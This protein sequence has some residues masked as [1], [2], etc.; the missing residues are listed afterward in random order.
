LREFIWNLTLQAADITYTDALE[1]YASVREAAKRRID[2]AET[3]HRELE[4][5]FRRTRAKGDEPT[6]KELERDIKAL[7]HGKRDGKIVIENIKP[8]L[9]GGGRKVIDEKFTDSGQFKEIDEGKITE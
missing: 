7:I 2:G 3:I 9:T 5:F 4:V 6:G 1:F 8:K